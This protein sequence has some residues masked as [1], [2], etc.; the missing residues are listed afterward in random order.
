MTTK[1]LLLITAALLFVLYSN[2]QIN[3][4]QINSSKNAGYL[5]IQSSPTEREANVASISQLGNQ[6][7]A[8][9]NQSKTGISPLGNQAFSFQNGSSNSLEI[10]Q[11]G[12]GNS[13]L[14]LQLGY[15]TD[16]FSHDNTNSLETIFSS[17]NLL[18]TSSSNGNH[19]SGSTNEVVC[20]QDGTSNALVSL[21]IGNENFISAGQTGKNNHLSITQF[22]NKNQVTGYK[23][24]NNS[25]DVLFD[26]VLQLGENLQLN[27][28]NG[29]TEKVLGDSFSQQ[30]S[31]LSLTLTS[32]LL[33][34]P[35]G[36]KV[37]QSGH[38]MHIVIDQSYFS[39]PM[40]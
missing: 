3:I 29:A 6:N 16:L 4:Q 23:Q 21:Q 39:F 2:A 34:A 37:T 12:D 9:I 11:K 32:S 22:G 40:K 33:S 5:S 17:A 1:P 7:T 18:G 30:G 8:K 36:I 38:D 31:D 19:A 14:S 25:E 35:G 10:D 20:Q 26:T 28:T 27:A 15:L 13:L 24:N